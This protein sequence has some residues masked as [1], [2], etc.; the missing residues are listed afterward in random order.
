MNYQWDWQVFLRDDGSGRTYIEWLISSW[1]W[2][3]S[4]AA[5]FMR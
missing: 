3:L 5:C 4:V 2:T 1:G